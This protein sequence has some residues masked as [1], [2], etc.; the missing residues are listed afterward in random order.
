MY[1]KDWLIGVA[2]T[3]GALQLTVQQSYAMDSRRTPLT[4]VQWVNLA[5]GALVVTV[6]YLFACLR[7]FDLLTR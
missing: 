6:V 3:F 2:V 5:L 4:I 1:L 7:A